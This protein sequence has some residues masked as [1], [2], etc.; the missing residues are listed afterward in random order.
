MTEPTE[1]L[2]SNRSF[3]LLFTTVC[4]IVAAWPLLDG[5][6]IRWQ[7]LLAAGAFLAVTL[8]RPSLLTPLNHAWMKFG[9]L[10]HRIVTPVIM[11][12]LF[13]LFITPLAL[14]MR[15]FGKRPIPLGFDPKMRSY[16]IVRTPAGP[17]PDSMKNQF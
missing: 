4:A 17:A 9:G 8:I 10:L 3:G 6:T 13:L 5:S 11:A 7:W 2:P 16:W 15:L 12:I 1:S 14:I